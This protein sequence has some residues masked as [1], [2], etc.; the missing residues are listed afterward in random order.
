MIGILDCYN[1]DKMYPM[2]GFGA[3]VKN[4]PEPKKPTHC[5]AL[6]GNIF[7]PEV[8]G[9]D[10]MVNAYLNALTKLDFNKER[11][12]SKII[13]NV[14]NYTSFTN[15]DDWH[16]NQKYNILLLLTDGIMDDFEETITQIVK[17]SE[18]PLSIIIVGIGEANFE[19]ME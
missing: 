3:N 17:G 4:A 13:E 15:Q 7:R 19:P 5:F 6:N 9:T 11:R 10:S 2:Y 1:S 12:F 8:K 18:L 14:N 16:G